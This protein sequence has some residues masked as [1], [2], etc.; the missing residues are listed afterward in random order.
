MENEKKQAPRPKG[1]KQY[2]LPVLLALTLLMRPLGLMIGA[3]IP[4]VMTNGLLHDAGLVVEEALL[5]GLPALALRPWRSRNMA[6]HGRRPDV[7]AAAFLMGVLAQVGMAALMLLLGAGGDG[8]TDLPGDALRW[9]ADLCAAA[10]IPAMCEE[11]FFRGSALTCLVTR[12]GPKRAFVLSVLIFA[13]MHGRLASLPAH[14]LVSAC[15][16]LLMLATGRLMTPILFHLGYNA[17]GLVLPV[18]GAAPWLAALLIPVLAG[19]GVAAANVDWR[20]KGTGLTG[21]ERACIGLIL[22]CAAL[23]YVM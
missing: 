14:L 19:A 6:V 16:S 15:C 7:C 8:T 4:G 12:T 22:V 9:I 20:R 23:G 10:V 13:L 18:F 21:A 5:W 11:A 17:A 1:V 2:T 3:M